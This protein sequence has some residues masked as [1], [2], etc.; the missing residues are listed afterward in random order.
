MHKII[1]SEIRQAGERFFH[2]IAAR[3]DRRKS[4]AKLM[5]EAVRAGQ[6]G[7]FV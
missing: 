7:V 2:Q 6:R 5:I 4:I 1:L 3:D